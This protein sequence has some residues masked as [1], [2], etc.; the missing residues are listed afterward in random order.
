MYMYMYIYMYVYTYVYTHT[1]TPTYIHTPAGARAIKFG[2]WSP[3][4]FTHLVVTI[5][6]RVLGLDSNSSSSNPLPG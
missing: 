4:A 2:V 5:K 1:H 3:L 6:G